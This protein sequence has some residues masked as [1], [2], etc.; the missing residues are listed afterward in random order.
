MTEQERY[1]IEKDLVNEKLCI[2]DYDDLICEV[3]DDKALIKLIDILNKQ[4]KIINKVTE[5]KDKYSHSML[6]VEEVNETLR[7]E[8]EKLKASKEYWKGE[9]L[10]NVSLNQILKNELDIAQEKGYKPTEEYKEDIKNI[11]ERR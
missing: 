5:I 8:N 7:E 11:K 4:N 2:W 1:A 9:C 6:D 10:S 3:D